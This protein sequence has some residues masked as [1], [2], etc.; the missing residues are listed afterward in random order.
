MPSEKYFLS[1]E[2]VRTA[3]IAGK[4][5]AGHI[6]IAQTAEQ[7]DPKA[8]VY[9]QMFALGYVRVLESAKQLHVD[10]PK[11]LTGG[12]RR[13]LDGK[14]IGEKRLIINSVDFMG[15]RG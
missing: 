14:L 13:F 11:P 4:P 5:G 12:Q 3:R 6:E 9:Q 2:G 15:S 1:S 10:A 8:D 7:L